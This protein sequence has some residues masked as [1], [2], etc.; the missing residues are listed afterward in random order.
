MLD[1]FF[2]VKKKGDG[3]DETVVKFYEKSR[4]SIYKMPEKCAKRKWF[5]AHRVKMKNDS[6]KGGKS[7]IRK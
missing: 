6:K 5:E 7:H 3:S 1:I 2:P 4:E